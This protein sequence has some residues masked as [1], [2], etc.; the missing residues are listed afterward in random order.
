MTDI[1]YLQTEPTKDA[2]I[3]AVVK[4]MDGQLEMNSSGACVRKAARLISEKPL[5]PLKYFG[6][7]PCTFDQSCD[8]K[9]GQYEDTYTALLDLK[10]SPSANANRLSI[11][12]FCTT[13]Q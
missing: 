11:I 10:H 4:Q 1:L 5:L 13:S 7:L 9:N 6:G 2:F 12:N 3:L 8:Y